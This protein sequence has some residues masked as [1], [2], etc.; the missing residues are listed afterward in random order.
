MA[1]AELLIALAELLIALARQRGIAVW[2][3]GERIKYRAP[4]GTETADLGA[5]V[6]QCRRE[7]RRMLPDRSKCEHC[8]KTTAVMVQM[9]PGPDGAPWVLCARCWLEGAS[10]RHLA[11]SRQSVIGG[12]LRV[13]SRARAAAL[14]NPRYGALNPHSMTSV[15]PAD[16]EASREPR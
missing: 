11:K 2:C 7:L 4:L 3:E 8:G 16:A 10:G 5:L 14:A 1:P 15:D 6:A 13:S 12:Y 9:Q